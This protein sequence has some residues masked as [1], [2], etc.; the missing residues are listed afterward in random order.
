MGLDHELFSARTPAA[1][2]AFDV[3]MLH[4]VHP[5]K[6]WNVGFAAL[7]EAKRRVPD[8]RAV[9][10]GV[11]RTGEVLDDWI[12][13]RLSPDQPTLAREVY[14]ATR[15]FV[16]SSKHEGF[17]FTAVEA[18]ACGAALVTTD[19]GGSRDYAVHGETAWVV[20][21]GDHQGL[22]DGIEALV[23]DERRR[24]RLAAAG[25]RAVRRFDWAEGAATLEAHLERYV[26][27]PAAFQ[28]PPA[29][30]VERAG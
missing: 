20:P 13:F 30:D 15:V 24:S 7:R 23:T 14:N 12:D 29:A 18:M 22:A 8:L 6:A 27:D 11:D 17:G 1:D 26:A 10:F 3:A 21:P 19:N 16:Q 2:R 25:E 9:V 28:H 5:T 4:N